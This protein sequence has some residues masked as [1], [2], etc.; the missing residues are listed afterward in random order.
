MQKNCRRY[1]NPQ[2]LFLIVLNLQLDFGGV[3]FQYAIN[4]LFIII[5][6]HSS[7]S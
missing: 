1:G 4:F 2:Q 5:E 6:Q 3:L 7:S